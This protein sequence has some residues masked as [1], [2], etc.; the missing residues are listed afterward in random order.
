MIFGM[1]YNKRA[2]FKDFKLSLHNLHSNI[3]LKSS[4]KRIIINKHIGETKYLYDVL[5]LTEVFS[6]LLFIYQNKYT[7]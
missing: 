7:S 6:D 4:L 1:T 2:K 3:F 5:F